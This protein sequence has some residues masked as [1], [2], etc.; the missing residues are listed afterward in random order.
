MSLGSIAKFAAPFLIDAAKNIGSKLLNYGKNQA[1]AYISNKLGD[2]GQQSS[3]PV[4]TIAN[5]KP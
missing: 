5:I 2:A 4:K 1:I 3:I